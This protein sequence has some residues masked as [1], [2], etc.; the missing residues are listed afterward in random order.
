MRHHRLRAATK[1]IQQ[2]VNQPALCCIT[3]NC[4]GLRKYESFPTF[5]TRRTTPFGSI[6][7]TMV[8]MVLYAD[9]PLAGS[10]SR[11][12]RMEDS[13]RPYISTSII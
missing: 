12:S 8:W 4:A 2:L 13:P 1:E 7:Y 3:R 6:L 9:L 10:E 5:L 11:I